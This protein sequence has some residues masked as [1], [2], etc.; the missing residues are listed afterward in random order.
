[1][2]TFKVGG[3]EV[4]LDHATVIDRLKGK[5]PPVPDGRNKQF[6]MVNRRRWPV[7]AAFSEASGL[8]VLTFPTGEAVRVMTRLGFPV[9]R[10][11]PKQ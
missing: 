8:N 9:T 11:D 10:E 7:K 5:T 2:Q 6:V 3:Q 4:R 1:M